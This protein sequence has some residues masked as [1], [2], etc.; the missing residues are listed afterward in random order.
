MPPLVDPSNADSVV[1][2]ARVHLARKDIPSAGRTLEGAVARGVESAAV[3]AL[4]AEV[5]EQSGHPENAIPAM[6]LSNIGRDT[7][8][9]LSLPRPAFNELVRD[10]SIQRWRDA[11][12]SGQAK[13]TGPPEILQ[14]IVNVVA[15]QEERART[16]KLRSR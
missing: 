16:R 11:F 14:L 1:R 10:G 6:R 9:R 15:R 7:K 8:V 12:A 3:Y 13:A 5:Y 4:L 2:L